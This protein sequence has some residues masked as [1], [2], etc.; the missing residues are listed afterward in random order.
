MR[1]DTE[2]IRLP[3]WTTVLADYRHAL[4]AY[5][6]DPGSLPRTAFLDRAVIR[7]QEAVRQPGLFE[8]GLVALSAG[9][10]RELVGGQHLAEE[11]LIRHKNGD[12]GLMVPEDVRQQ[13]VCDRSRPARHVALRD[14]CRRRIVGGHGR[15][16]VG[17]PPVRAGGVLVVPEV[18]HPESHANRTDRGR[19][20]TTEYAFR[21]T[22]DKEPEGRVPRPD[23]R[24]PGAT[25]GDGASPSSSTTRRPR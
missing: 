13:P 16:P 22:W 9:A 15:E 8:L 3:T 23:P 7:L 1:R 25:A 11:F 21:G 2:P 10:I 12:F 14:P 24:A 19:S 17:D 20:S 6:A 18:P 5:R 4:D